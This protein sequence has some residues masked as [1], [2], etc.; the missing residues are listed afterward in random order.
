MDATSE[1]EEIQ[2]I[3]YAIWQAEG[4]P[5]GRE[6]EHWERARTIYAGRRHGAGGSAPEGRSYEPKVSSYPTGKHGGVGDVRNTGPRNPE[7]LPATN[8]EGYVAIP[9]EEDAVAGALGADAQT[10]RRRDRA[11]GPPKA[12]SVSSADCRPRPRVPRP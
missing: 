12:R 5:E 9:S 10:R 2:R 6:R 8:A 1:Q 4:E 7:P 11:P 3:A